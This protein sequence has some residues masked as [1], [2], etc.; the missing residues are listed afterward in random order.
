MTEGLKYT[1]THTTHLHTYIHTN[2]LDWD[3]LSLEMEVWAKGGGVGALGSTHRFQSASSAS[4]FVSA[5]RTCAFL[6]LRG[7]APRNHSF[8][9]FSKFKYWNVKIRKGK[10]L[11]V[12]LL[13]QFLLSG[14]QHMINNAHKRGSLILCLDNDWNP[15]KYLFTV[16]DLSAEHPVVSFFFNWIYWGDTG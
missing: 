8:W 9:W 13:L 14:S 5:V 4:R 10:T 16:A 7:I 15:L 2:S 11:H 3:M 12:M 6:F 1:C